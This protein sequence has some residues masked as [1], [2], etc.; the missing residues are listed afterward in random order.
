M[1]FLRKR[2][3]TA[4]SVVAEIKWPVSG[5]PI[6]SFRFFLF[7]FKPPH[8]ARV[9]GITTQKDSKG[10]LSKVTFDLKKHKTLIM[11]ILEKLGAVEDPFEKAWNDPNNM[12]VEELREKLLAKVRSR[13]WQ[14]S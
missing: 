6:S 11:P 13:E 4:V 14:K 1:S 10:N 5:N 7:L 12:T 3:E 8:M 9:A 2:F